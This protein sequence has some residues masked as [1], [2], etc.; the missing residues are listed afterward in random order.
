MSSFK[1]LT[2]TYDVLNEQGTFSQ[3]DTLSGNVQLQLEKET[4]IES[5]F[6]KAKGDAN[7]HWS[8]RHGNRDRSYSAH[9]R[10]F[11]LKQFLIPESAKEYIILLILLYRRMP[12]SFRGCHGKIVYKL[13]AKLSRSWRMDRTAEKEFN[14]ASTSITNFG[15][16]NSFFRAVQERQAA[17]VGS[18]RGPTFSSSSLSPQVGS[19]DKVMGPFSKG[20]VHMDVVVDK[21]ACAPGETVN[22]DAKVNN[23]SSK[24]MTPK[25]SIKQ[26][27]VY[28][29]EGS[30]K[31]GEKLIC[32]MVG[33]SISP[34]TEK[35]ITCAMKIPADQSLTIQN[36]D[37]ISVEYQL[38]V[39]LDISFASDAKVKFPLLVIP[40]DLTS[41]PH[42]GGAMGQKYPPGAVGGPSNSDFP[43]FAVP[44]GHYP[45]NS[46]PGT[47]G[48]P[49]APGPYST[50]SPEY[51]AQRPTFPAKPPSYPGQ[52][53]MYPAQPSS[54][55][56]N[57]NNPLPQPASPYATPFS[58]PVL[59]PPPTAPTFYPPPSA[60]PMIN[61]FPTAPTYNLPP[62][63]TM[64][65]TNFLSQHDE[66]PPSYTSL[67]PSSTT[68]K[69]PTDGK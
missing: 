32:H 56:Q 45:V 31:H 63:A 17:G 54:M 46:G 10:Y 27:V 59:H 3:G 66:E 2:L 29:A 34:N 20:Q 43:P 25:F 6:I 39:Y 62:S 21:R 51:P 60:P 52:P 1:D 28:R 49:A 47:Y 13:E 67:Y 7:V 12:S 57:Y 55:G 61:P 24:D 68:K 41:G 65:N 38:K 64:M 15:H 58:S 8:E 44:V 19:T 14:F 9:D 30:T 33:D 26:K 37:I 35:N 53:P 42:P 4:K 50:V 69:S 22:I 16:P 5:F 36:C 48:Y 40:S 23:S 11:K 18:A